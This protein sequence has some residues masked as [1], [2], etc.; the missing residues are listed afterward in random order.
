MVRGNLSHFSVNYIIPSSLI[1]LILFIKEKQ[2][3]FIEIKKKSEIIILNK[4]SLP[5]F[6]PKK[7]I[8]YIYIFIY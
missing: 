3:V 5:I 2:R 4:F 1:L 6:S 7:K 8:K